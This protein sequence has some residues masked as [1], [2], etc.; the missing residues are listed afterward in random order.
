M[1]KSIILLV[2]LFLLFAG[3]NN[4]NSDNSDNLNNS[5]NS[6]NANNSE[7]ASGLFS[8]SECTIDSTLTLQNGNWEYLELLDTLSGLITFNI[9]FTISDNE[10]DAITYTYF[11]YNGSQI[12]TEQMAELQSEVSSIDNNRLL[13]NKNLSYKKNSDA[14]KYFGQGQN[15]PGNEPYTVKVYF[16]YLDQ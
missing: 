7:S 2:G 13:R 6:E 3:C 11:S 1:K 10:L 15:E 9:K 8:E 12:S 14:T 5:N 4:G 16:K